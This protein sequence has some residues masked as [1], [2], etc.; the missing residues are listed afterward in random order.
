MILGSSMESP[1]GFGPAGMRIQGYTLPVL[2]SRLA[3][4]LELASLAG[5]AGDGDTG[6]TI[7]ITTASCSTITAMYPTAE[8]SLIGITSITAADS[9]AEPDFTA[10]A[11][12]STAQRRSTDSRDRMPRPALILVRSAALIMEERPE[13]SLLVGSPASVEVSTE[14]EASTAAAVT[15][16]SFQRVQ[17]QLMIRRKK[18]CTRTK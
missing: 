16:N 10:P 17:T 12:V 6:D 15:V 11:L 4:A 14:V 5:L 3:S 18:S 13:A 9:M 8:S 7:G 1:L 2:E